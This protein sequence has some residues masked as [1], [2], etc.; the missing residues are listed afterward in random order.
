[1]RSQSSGSSSDLKVLNPFDWTYTTTHPGSVGTTPS[2]STP[3]P[4]FEP[5]P[6]GHPGIPISLLAR[7][8]IPVTFFEEIPLFEDELG[9]NG[10]AEVNVRVVSRRRGSPQSWDQ[11]AGPYARVANLSSHAR[12]G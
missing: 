3:P 7:H 5:A 11:G 1:M 4:A 10:I 6:E 12:S 8:D 9:D 2:S